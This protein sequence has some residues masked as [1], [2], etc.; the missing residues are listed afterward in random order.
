M[1]RLNVKLV[2]QSL[3]RQSGLYIVMAH[4]TSNVF[5]IL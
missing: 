4:F 3:A 1:L 2:Y 5:R